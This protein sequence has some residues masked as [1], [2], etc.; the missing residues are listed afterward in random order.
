MGYANYGFKGML[1]KGISGNV[2]LDAHDITSNGWNMRGGLAGEHLALFTAAGAAKVTWT[3]ATREVSLSSDDVSLCSFY[4]VTEYSTNLMLYDYYS[5]IGRGCNVV[6]DIV[7]D[8]ARGCV[9]RVEAPHQRN[10][11]QPRPLLGE[12]PRRWSLL[13]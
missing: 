13:P 7:H 1:V 9:R 8:P 2:T 6:Q 10:G 12:R 5:K 11:S 4:H 3:P